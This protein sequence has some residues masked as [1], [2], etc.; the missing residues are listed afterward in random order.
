MDA[1]KMYR[2]LI[3]T[4]I[5]FTSLGCASIQDYQYRKSNEWR[6]SRAWSS[7]KASI[8]KDCRDSDFKQGFLDGYVA[9]ATG[10]C[11][12]LP[13][14][15]PPKYWDAKYQ[16]CE[17]RTQIEHYFSGWQSGVV[18][19]EKCGRQYWH[20]IP[21]K[22]CREPCVPECENCLL[23]D[24]SIAKGAEPTQVSEAEPQL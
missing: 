10:S 13:P 17:G 14:V 1:L 11:G 21:T 5:A 7:A 3:I 23:N 18:A 6:A 24:Q 15:P 8:P 2:W 9:V 22:S 20:R 16:S 4:S 19:A 12:Q